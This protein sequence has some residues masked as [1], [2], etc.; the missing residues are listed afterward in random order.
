MILYLNRWGYNTTMSLRFQLSQYTSVFATHSLPAVQFC[1]RK[2]DGDTR[3][4]RAACTSVSGLWLAN[5]WNNLARQ[6]NTL[7]NEGGRGK[8]SQ[9][10]TEQMCKHQSM[11]IS[12]SCAESQ[13]Y[14]TQLLAHFCSGLKRESSRNVIKTCGVCPLLWYL[15]VQLQWYSV[16]VSV[17]WRPNLFCRGGTLAPHSSRSL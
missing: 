2:Q 5:I 8:K 7:T 13:R 1:S 9:N 12:R 10:Q 3:P 11:I 6:T 15:L 16:V 17:L 4:S 14:V